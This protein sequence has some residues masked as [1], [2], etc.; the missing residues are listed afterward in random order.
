MLAFVGYFLSTHNLQSALYM[1]LCWD[2]LLRV[3]EPFALPCLHKTLLSHLQPHSL[4]PDDVGIAIMYSNKGPDQYTFVSDK[5][6]TKFITALLSQVPE[7]SPLFTAPQFFNVNLISFSRF[8]CFYSHPISSHSNRI[9]G[10]IY[11]L[12]K[13]PR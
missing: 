7:N 13:V 8:F 12:Q 2:G 10:A 4:R 3:N 6:L 1:T 5:V 11:L 9:V